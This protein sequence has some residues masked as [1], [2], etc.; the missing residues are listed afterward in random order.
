MLA[1]LLKDLCVAHIVHGLQLLDSLLI[2]NTNELL[3][4]RARSVRAIEV[5]E[6]LVGIDTKEA[7]D[8]SVIRQGGAETDDPDVVAGLLIAAQ[9]SAHDTLNNRTTL[10]VKQMDF[11]DTDQLDEVD[12]AGIG[13]LAGD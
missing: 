9:G 6:A 7:S 3:L 8:I 11:I 10:I 5:E 1:N 2:G 12:I 13:G 4:Q